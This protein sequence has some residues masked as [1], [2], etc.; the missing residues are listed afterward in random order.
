M[1]KNVVCVLVACACAWPL[2]LSSC[3]SP[4][5]SAAPVVVDE[6]PAVE[7]A[8]SERLTLLHD[9]PADELDQYFSADDPNA[10]LLAGMLDRILESFEFGIDDVH[11]DGDSATVVVTV[12]GVDVR[13]ALDRTLSSLSDDPDL[14][15]IGE[16]YRSGDLASFAQPFFERFMSSLD[17]TEERA[18]TQLILVLARQNG[19]WAIE[20]DSM[21]A[22]VSTLL[23]V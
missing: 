8:V 12:S 17:E 22:V 16:R 18:S 6:K 11:V 7:K 19:S 9:M 5:T 20:Q 13:K 10:S 23:G 21:D 14:E 3:A 4:D 2:C 1:R 15:E